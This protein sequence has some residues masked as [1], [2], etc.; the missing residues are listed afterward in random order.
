MIEREEEFLG[1]LRVGRRITTVSRTAAMGLI[2]TPGLILLLSV[3]SAALLGVWSTIATVLMLIVLALTLLNIV[4]LLG[5]SSERGGTSSLVHESLGGFGGFLSGW[6]LLAGCLAL[7]A[8][9]SRVIGEEFLILFPSLPLN[10]SLFGFCVIFFLT[11][12]QVFRFSSGRGL[13]LPMVV[14]FFLVVLAIF[15]SELPELNPRLFQEAP[16]FTSGGLMQAAAWLVMVFICIEA[17]M[18]SRR[19]I[20]DSTRRLPPSLVWV[21]LG[22]VV[23][24]VLGQFVIAGL[25]AYPL[26]REP[27]SLLENLGRASIFQSWIIIVAVILCF[28]IAAN[29]CMM[30]AARQ[31]YA[32]SQRGIIPKIFRSVPSPFRLPPL[33]FGSVLIITTPFLFMGTITEIMDLAAALILIPVLL[34]NL[35]AIRSRQVEPDRRRILVTPFFPL[36]PAIALALAGVMLILVPLKGLFWG[37]V[38]VLLGFVFYQ[39]YGRIHLLE[40]QEGVVVFG[41]SPEREKKEGTFRILVPVTAGVERQ[42][43]LELATTFA[44]QL[45]GELIALQVLVIPDP[46]AME[47][48]QRLA[49]ERNQLFQW[50]TRYAARSGVPIY[51][52]TRLA[53]S[54]QEGIL[55]SAVEEQ[56]DLI[57]LSWA[58]GG[59]S[60]SVR[61]GRVLDPVIRQ[62]PCDVAVL[63][64]HPEIYL[65]AEE[66]R[67]RRSDA[68]GEGIRRALPIER[69]LV[70]TAGGPHA[71][72]ASRLALLL[73]RE[74]EA[75]TMGVYVAGPG[76]SDEEVELGKARIQQ[77]LTAMRQQVADLPWADVYGQA[78]DALPFE[79]QVIRADSVLEGIIQAGGES[80]LVLMGASEESMI[81]QVLFGTLVEDVARA[82][83]TPVLMVKRYRGLPRIW[84]QRLW[85]AIVR[86]LPSLTGD[87]RLE[88]YKQVRRSSRPDV[89]FFIMIGLSAIIAGYG[90][91]QD[92]SAVII[93]GMLVAP[94]FSPI[95][96]ISLS[97]VMG[98]IR[99]LRLAIEATLKGIFLAVGV[100]IFIAAISPL[101]TGGGEIAARVA[102]NLFDLAVALASGAAGAYAISRK[103]VAA[104]LPGV[105]IAA[106]LVPPLCVVGIGLAAADMQ[107][108]GGGGLLFITNLVAIVMAGTVV[109]LLLGF[110]PTEPGERAARLRRGLVVSLVLLVAISIP[111]AMV[112]VRSVEESRLRLRINDVLVQ[113][114]G[115]DPRYE[116]LDFTF[117][118][119]D[120][121]VDISVR[122]YAQ[123]TPTSEQVSAWRD[124][125]S[126]ALGEPVHFN[127]MSIAMSEI[128]SSA[129]QPP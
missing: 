77:T 56:C 125:L 62:A 8:I 122:I 115:S 128:E 59:I 119:M 43:V 28:F 98:D 107:V 96:A 124:Q 7:A 71:P 104:A 91:L 41:P 33:L 1:E 86:A 116:L 105:A 40:A 123:E 89:D 81:D 58:I 25:R 78:G 57:V 82:C 83:S 30:V 11:V 90:L 37:V 120:R 52:V 60:Q 75:T 35:A 129:N 72:L 112:F 111:L 88:V 84:F 69:I 31:L 97:I 4:E 94:L 5:G 27:I 49:G 65:A 3:R 29:T 32:L 53:R 76:T 126:Q 23:L 100:A 64:F 92:S 42:L 50:S 16:P 6:S 48:G 17:V 80:D 63:A 109:F 61:L 12:V 73:A 67:E 2:L 85:D 74:Y 118:Q 68:N 103:D 114:I 38:W 102:P 20:R 45:G 113:E 121:Q 55:A 93:G 87:D 19:L 18:T 54:V 127:L 106:A 51:S 22:S 9:F 117:E 66:E 10:P 95:L 46:L 13:T 47:Q 39:V 15:A 24:L 34:I 70:T 108:A 110:R 44:K 99:L 26:E 79:S 14:L 101:R 21:L 36:V